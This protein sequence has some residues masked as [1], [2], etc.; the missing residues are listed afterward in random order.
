[1]RTADQRGAAQAAQQL[2]GVRAAAVFGERLHVILAPG[3]AGTAAA[4]EPALASAG[5]LVQD[6][7]AVEASMEDVFID[8]V[9]AGGVS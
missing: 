6:I 1:M 4:L 7:V 9:L 2:P 3:R 8:R 5:I